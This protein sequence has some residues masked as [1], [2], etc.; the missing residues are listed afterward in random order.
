ME[1]NLNTSSVLKSVEPLNLT[2]VYM[3]SLAAQQHHADICSYLLRAVISVRTALV[4]GI[5]VGQKGNCNILLSRWNRFSPT[6]PASLSPCIFKNLMKTKMRKTL[7]WQHPQLPVN[8]SK[9]VL[10][11]WC[12]KLVRYSIKRNSKVCKCVKSDISRAS[13][14]HLATYCWLTETD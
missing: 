3:F 5:L 11:V 8:A 6:Y 2:Q 14:S 9:Y 10:L 1:Y 7:P 12:L 13:I 4:S